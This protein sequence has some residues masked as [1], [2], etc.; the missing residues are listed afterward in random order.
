MKTNKQELNPETVDKIIAELKKVNQ[1]GDE[2]IKEG[3]RGFQISL[4]SDWYDPINISVSE[5]LSQTL[6]GTRYVNNKLGALITI[7]KLPDGT[8]AT[9]FVEYKFGDATEGAYRVRSSGLVT[10]DKNIIQIHEH[11][12]QNESYILILQVPKLTYDKNKNIYS[13]ILKTFSIDC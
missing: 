13:D 5:H 8:D 2:S 10:L 6:E 11:S 12:C 7:I 4:D 9:Q 3:M 1:V